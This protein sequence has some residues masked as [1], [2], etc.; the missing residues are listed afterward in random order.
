[1]TP[2]TSTAFRGAWQCRVWLGL[3][4][5]GMVLLFSGPALGQTAIQVTKLRDLNFGGC[6]NTGGVTYTVAA[7][8]SP[9]AG[10]CFGA[11]SAQFTIT[12]DPNRRALVTL[13]NRV[14]VTNGIASLQVNITD[15]VGSNRICLGP[16]G[17]VT[18]YL[19][20]SVTLPGG[21][22]SS[23]GLFINADQIALTYLG[24]GC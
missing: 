8:A 15:S 23:F 22:A 7:A 9:G 19:G 20:G 10:A 5:I 14:T 3:L 6:D 12:G 4:G 21:G 2:L 17:S 24:G 18:V 11:T 13:P 1:M 16:T